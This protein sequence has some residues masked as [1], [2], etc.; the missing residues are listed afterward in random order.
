[1]TRV[2]YKT[3]EEWEAIKP[4]FLQLYLD[5]DLPLTEVIQ[6][7]AERHGFLASTKMFKTRISR[8]EAFKYYK[9]SDKEELVKF[10]S[11]STDA[12]PI[13]QPKVT[14]RGKPVK[15]DRVE[16]YQAGLAK[17][18]RRHV[19]RGKCTI[20]RNGGHPA[21]VHCKAAVTRSS[22]CIQL[23]VS[24]RDELAMGAAAEFIRANVSKLSHDVRKRLRDITVDNM[25]YDGIRLLSSGSHRA[26]AMI[27]AACDRMSCVIK[28]DPRPLLNILARACNAPDWVGKHDLLETLFSFSRS[29]SLSILP[30]HDLFRRLMQYSETLAS[31]QQAMLPILRY[32]LDLAILQLTSHNGIAI[33]DTIMDSLWVLVDAEDFTTARQYASTLL[34]HP[35]VTSV[36][37]ADLALVRLAAFS[38]YREG[39]YCSA[40]VKAREGICLAEHALAS[41]GSKALAAIAANELARLYAILAWSYKSLEEIQLSA[42]AFYRAWSTLVSC[43]GKVALTTRLFCEWKDLM[44]KYPR[45]EILEFVRQT[46]I[47]MAPDDNAVVTALQHSQS[48]ALKTDQE[49]IIKDAG[50][51]ASSLWIPSRTQATTNTVVLYAMDPCPSDRFYGPT[52]SPLSTKCWSTRDEPILVLPTER[53]YMRA[54]NV[55]CTAPAQDIVDVSDAPIV[56]DNWLWLADEYLPTPFTP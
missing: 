48:Y 13:S 16:R 47:L 23:R 25:V 8:W 29:L 42:A 21:N 31:F 7:L 51:L 45:L 50:S 20:S 22:A 2:T 19:L 4:L 9:V 6:E 52:A 1:M 30:R 33:F 54:A 37:W 12:K 3:D 44:H 17:Q 43:V 24:N 46:G 35:A 10:M 26:W 55:G 53:S 5:Q 38:S 39:E 56:S 36:P 28:A 15:W 11:K 14:I 49:S 32:N 40:I 27:H 18:R 34:K 41:A